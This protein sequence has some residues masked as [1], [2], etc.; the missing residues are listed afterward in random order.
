MT[1]EQAAQLLA[2]M[3]TIRAIADAAQSAS[4]GV[5]STGYPVRSSDYGRVAGVAALAADAVFQTLNVAKAYAECPAA[6]AALKARCH[7]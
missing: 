4:Y 6:T 7:G 2:A 3:D 5:P 1:D